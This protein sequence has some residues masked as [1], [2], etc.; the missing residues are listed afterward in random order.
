MKFVIVYE[1]EYFWIELNNNFNIQ[2]DEYIAKTIGIS[3]E[4]YHNELQQ[5]RKT[6]DEDY[7]NDNDNF[8]FVNDKEIINAY[9][10][11][12]NKYGVMLAL[13]GE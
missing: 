10:Y 7:H 12:N 1:Y 13:L 4:H 5:F 11:L 2:N 6:W 3:L 8:I 9:Q